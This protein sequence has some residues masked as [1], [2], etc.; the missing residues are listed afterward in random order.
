MSFF[1][2]FQ[3]GILNSVSIFIRHKCDGNE[4]RQYFKIRKVALH[5]R[6]A[7][8]NGLNIYKWLIIL[9]FVNER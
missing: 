5:C 3:N 4:A 9:L 2:V 1:Y 7:L 8:A 6:C